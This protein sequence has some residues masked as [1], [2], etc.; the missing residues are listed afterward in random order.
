MVTT[1]Q[2]LSSADLVLS[3]RD[4]LVWASWSDGRSPVPLGE[5]ASVLLEMQTFI[6]QS[7]VAARLVRAA[8]KPPHSPAP[9]KARRDA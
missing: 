9:P 5:H 8:R 3:L 2:T 4:G 1:D 7:E 6:L